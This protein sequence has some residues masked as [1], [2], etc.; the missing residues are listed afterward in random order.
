MGRMPY[1]DAENLNFLM[2]TTFSESITLKATGLVN[3][4]SETLTTSGTLSGDSD[5][6]L[7]SQDIGTT[8][9]AITQGEISTS[10]GA[11]F[12]FV[13]NLDTANFVTLGYAS[14]VVP[15]TNTFKLEAGCFGLFPIPS[16]ALNALADTA[17][18][19]IL[20]KIVEK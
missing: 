9:E 14:P 13:Q 17:T 2:A 5:I 19:K 7:E 20:K 1:S 11:K 8:T 6:V 16:G 12:L 3:L 18:V 4:Q 15:G 10:G